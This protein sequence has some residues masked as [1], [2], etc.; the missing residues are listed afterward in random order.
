MLFRGE[1]YLSVIASLSTFIFFA[2][3]RRVNRVT[4]THPHSI[5]TLRYNFR[6]SLG[7]GS[8]S[9]LRYAGWLVYNEGGQSPRISTLNADGLFI[10]EDS[11]RLVMKGSRARILERGPR[12]DRSLTERKN[13]IHHQSVRE[14]NEAT[15]SSRSGALGPV[16][17]IPRS[18]EGANDKDAPFSSHPPY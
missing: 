13:P 1:L 16:R 15:T 12:C 18:Q 4:D 8:K 2:S 11:K 7:H 17:G 14:A 6:A 10:F 5:P 9:G 3:N